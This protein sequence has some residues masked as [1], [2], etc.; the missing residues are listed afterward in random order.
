MKQIKLKKTQRGLS[1]LMTMTMLAIIGIFAEVALS[2]YQD[3]I[4]Q[5]QTTEQRIRYRYTI[6]TV[7]SRFTLSSLSGSLPLIIATH[8][9]PA[10]SRA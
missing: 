1:L 2:A 8:I 6:I 7:P 10:I 3:Y 5:E 4:A 9:P